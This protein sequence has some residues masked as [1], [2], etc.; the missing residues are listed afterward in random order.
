LAYRR[1]FESSSG[2]CIACWDGG[3]QVFDITDP[4]NPQPVGSVEFS[5]RALRVFAPN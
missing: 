2:L 3:L 4:Q 5:G 1:R